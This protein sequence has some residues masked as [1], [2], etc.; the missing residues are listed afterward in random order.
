MI[1][2]KMES[3]LC[4]VDGF[5]YLF[6]SFFGT[7]SLKNANGEPIGAIFGMAERLKRLLATHRSKRWAV[8]FDAPGATF[9]DNLYPSYKANRESTPSEFVA[10]INPTYLL[11]RAMGFPVLVI[12]G[13]E[14]DDVIATLAT[15]AR[16]KGIPTRIFSADKDFAQLVDDY[17]V[18]ID[19]AKNTS[20]DRPGVFAKFGVFPEQIVD[21]LALVGDS[22]DNVP[23][24]FGVGP[25]TA[26]KWLG[27]YGSLDKILLQSK[28]IKGKVGEQL[29]ASVHQFPLTRKLLTLHKEVSLPVSCDELKLKIPDPKVLEN[30]LNQ[31]GFQS[32]LAAQGNQMKSGELIF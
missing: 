7:P 30:L 12:P 28:K 5:S 17:V 2:T 20:L 14:A 25:K 9:R 22:S 1:N 11:V 18:L 10:Q 8:V 32:W 15:R 16:E 4:L 24:V 27:E 23:G 3:P 13:V 26:A 19:T 21:Y 6:R 29:R 31:L